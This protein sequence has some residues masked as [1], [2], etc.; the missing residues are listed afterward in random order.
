MNQGTHGHNNENLRGRGISRLDVGRWVEFV[1]QE[2]YLSQTVD[3]LL[4]KEARDFH[5]TNEVKRGTR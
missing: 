4:N 5:R 1:R 2:S 3:T